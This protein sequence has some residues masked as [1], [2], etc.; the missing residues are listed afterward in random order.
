MTI[1]ARFTR[2][3]YLAL[4]ESPPGVRFELLDGELVTMNDPLP[5][6]QKAVVNILTALVFWSR[7]APDRGQV[8]LPIDT[9]IGPDTIFGPDLQWY[10]ADRGLPS[11]R[12]RPWPAGD[13]VV[14]VASPSTARYDAEVKLDRYLA[15]GAREV[16]LVR[17]D[18]TGATIVRAQ[19]G[20]RRTLEV[21]AG[22]TLESPLLPGF[23]FGLAELA[24]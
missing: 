17:T 15:A 9:D 16:W 5:V 18:P 3:E 21:A 1:A 13:L 4:P 7:A 22:G 10:A 14:E 6:H 8:L 2:E 19:D 23:A 20:G 11:D 24:G 12:E